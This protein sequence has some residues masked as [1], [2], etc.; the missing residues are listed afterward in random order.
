MGDDMECSWG[1]DDGPDPWAPAQIGAFGGADR[2]LLRRPDGESAFDWPSASPELL[3]LQEPEDD[4]RSQAIPREFASPGAGEGYAEGQRDLLHETGIAHDGRS[5][6]QLHSGSA[7]EPGS[8]SG[9]LGIH[10]I[11]ENAY[12]VAVLDRTCAHDDSIPRSGE[13]DEISDESPS[14]YDAGG[15]RHLWWDWNREEHAGAYPSE[16]GNA[17]RQWH[18]YFG[19]G[20]LLRD[21]YSTEYEGQGLVRRVHGS[22]HSSDRGLPWGDRPYRTTSDDGSLSSQGS[23]EGWHDPVQPEEGVHHEQH[24]PEDVVSDPGASGYMGNG[25]SSPTNYEDYAQDNP[26][27]PECAIHGTGCVFSCRWKDLLGGGCMFAC[28]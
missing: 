14:I 16:W 18:A 27:E 24:T 17:R 6:I 19:P 4:V 1:L 22:G 7:S 9:H 26:V 12:G 20:G 28:W 5:G 21:E 13:A 8:P 2:V 10:G 23:D 15:L 3:A 25:S 11:C